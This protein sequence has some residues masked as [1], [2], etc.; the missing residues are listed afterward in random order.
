MTQAEYD[1]LTGKP[2]EKTARTDRKKLWFAFLPLDGKL[3]P[4]GCVLTLPLPPTKNNEPRHSGELQRF[5]NHWWMRSRDAWLCAGQPRFQAVTVTPIFHLLKLNRDTDNC[6]GWAWKRI[7]DA[8]KGHMLHD[9]APKYLR[10]NAPVLLKAEG[11]PRL[12]IIVEEVQSGAQ[13]GE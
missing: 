12:E 3:T 13:E 8:W 5:K 1:A 2:R 9:D 4:T 10:L 11:L 6:I 7:Q